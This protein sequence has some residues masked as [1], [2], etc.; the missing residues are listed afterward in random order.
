MKNLLFLFVCCVSL[1]TVAQLNP[2]AQFGYE[3]KNE[4]VINKSDK[5]E[6]ANTDTS[7]TRQLLLFDF[8][9]KKLF[10]LN[11][12]D[13]IITIYDIP[14]D[15]LAKWIS[16]DPK[17][18]KAPDWSPYRSFFDNPI[19]FIDPDG[20]W[21]ADSKGNLKA[22]K[23]DNAQTLAKFQGIKYGEAL[24]QLKS[25]GYTVNSKGIL[26]LKVGDQLMLK[27][28]YTESIKNSTGQFSTDVMM[29]LAP[30]PAG[31]G[32]GIDRGTPE[33]KYNCWG[34]AIAGSQGNKIDNSVGIP[35]GSTFDAK[36]SS[37]YTPTTQANAQF[38]KTVLRFADASGVQH[39]AVYYGKNNAGEIYVYSKNGWHA[40]PEVMKLSDLML[41]IPDYGTVQ[42]INTGESGYYQPK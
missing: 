20:Q 19:R 9:N 23:G 12:A 16:V 35:L 38:G 34:S 37:D 14:K 15:V 6:I 40:K 32:P 11:R 8:A 4:Y 21:E 13:S 31:S 5:L 10:V 39:G 25:Q 2:Y 30:A 36:L 24:K 22:E 41:K 17:A 26:N 18:S 33:D 3:P 27:N 1:N 28:N 42:G 7:S 29:R